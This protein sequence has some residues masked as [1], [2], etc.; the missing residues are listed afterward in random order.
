ML[1]ELKNWTIRAK[2][3]RVK[4]RKRKRNLSKKNIGNR[5]RWRD[6]LHNQQR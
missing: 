1:Q 5:A 2:D 6:Y 3:K 4:E